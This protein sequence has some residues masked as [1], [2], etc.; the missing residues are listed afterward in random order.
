MVGCDPS[1]EGIALATRAYP[2]IQFKVL[3]VY[4]EPAVLGADSFDAVVST[5]VIEHLY[6]PRSLPRF[7]AKVLRPKGHLILSTPY[8]GYLKNLTLALT[9]E[10]DRHHSPLWDN[11]HIKFWSRATLTKLLSEE[12]F[13]VTQFIGVARLP[14]LW[15]SMILICQ[16]L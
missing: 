10:W 3:G 11:G 15:K 5:E 8:H 2:N 14:F 7:A 9:D 12:G 6:F 1:Q 4:D 13:N 16:K